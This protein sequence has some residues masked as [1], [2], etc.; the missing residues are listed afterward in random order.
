LAL[1]I[2][3]AAS[4][5]A[6]LINLS[7]GTP[8]PARAAVLGAAVNDAVASG[9]MRVDLSHTATVQAFHRPGFGMGSGGRIS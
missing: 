4:Q 5:G 7:L 8:N 1:G 6:R 3:R 9:A 2:S